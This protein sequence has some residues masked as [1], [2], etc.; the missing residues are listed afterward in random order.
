MFW[1]AFVMRLDVS[2]YLLKRN[3]FAFVMERKHLYRVAS[4]LRKNFECIQ[5]MKRK[6]VH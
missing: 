1:S 6:E 5:R 3:I 2:T 4:V